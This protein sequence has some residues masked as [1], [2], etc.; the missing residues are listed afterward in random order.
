MEQEA[1]KNN[2]Y[3]AI[4]KNGEVLEFKEL[5][6]PELVQNIQKICA[7]Y[8]VKIDGS[9]ARY[10]VENCGTNMQDLINEIRKLIEH[11]GENG[12]ITE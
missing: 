4:E 9:T 10:F 3:K 7:A 2:L 5:K 8:K 1:E 6:L 11:A 12:T